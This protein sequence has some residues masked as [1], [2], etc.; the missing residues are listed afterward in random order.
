MTQQG[1]RQA[2]ARSQSGFA[3]A[4]NYNEDLMRLFDADGIPA[5][6]FN[7]RQLRWINYRLAASHTNVN[8]AMQ[9]FATASGAYNWSSLGSLSFRSTADFRV[10]M[11]AGSTYTRTGSASGLALAGTLQAFA[12]NAPQRTDRG[13]ALEPARTNAA[14]QSQ[15]FSN[16]AWALTVATIT[17]NVTTAPDGTTTAARFL[18]SAG[19]S[20]H[21]LYET[22]GVPNVTAGQTQAQSWFLKFDTHRYVQ[23]AMFSGPFGVN[24]WANV[25][26]V[27]GVLGTVGSAATATLLALADGWY[28]ATITCPVTTTDASGAFIGM[29]PAATSGR[30]ASFVAV[31][32]EAVFVWGAQMEIG[33]N[34][35]SYIP[36]SGTEAT[37]GLPVLTETVPSGRTK[38]LLTYADAS[39]TLVTGLLPGGTLDYVTPVVAANKGRVGA[40]ELV[41]RVWQA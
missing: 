7:E 32:T 2:S 4:T 13:L 1:A 6:T 21:Q 39:T 27:G 37:R 26:L 24:A 20:A 15:A 10:A 36:T 5:G 35:S 22:V 9:A 28:L 33:A 19:S 18:A 3:T 40:S 23:L 16:A 12:A 34:P 31:G 17:D 11:P 14:I 29:V 38:A 30:S 8:N 25:D 41:T